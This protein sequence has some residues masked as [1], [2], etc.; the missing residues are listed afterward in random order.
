M[1]RTMSRRPRRLLCHVCL[2][3]SASMSI[4]TKH[5]LVFF[6]YY[7]NERAPAKELVRSEHVKSRKQ[8][9]SPEAATNSA[10]QMCPDHLNERQC[11]RMV[12]SPRLR[13]G[14]KKV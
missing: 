13:R 8:G 2:L 9:M 12:F 1:S 7:D 4:A 6:S 3:L 10:K 5:N 14:H 11:V